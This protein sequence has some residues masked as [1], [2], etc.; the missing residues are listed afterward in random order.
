MNGF[1]GNIALLL[2]NEL[3]MVLRTSEKYADMVETGGFVAVMSFL[4]VAKKG[5]S[6]EVTNF[7]KE[8]AL[9][10]GMTAT[11][12]SDALRFAATAKDSAAASALDA[13]AS[14]A[15]SLSTARSHSTA[16]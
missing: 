16:K 6:D 13:K 3:R 5:T 2:E 15:T 10:N 1:H 12:S 8:C 9:Y 14:A 4:L 7:L 11:E